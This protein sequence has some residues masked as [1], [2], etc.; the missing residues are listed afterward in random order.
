MAENQGSQQSLDFSDGVI[1]NN[2][3]SR[4]IFIFQTLYV[5]S[6]LLKL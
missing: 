5:S 3:K 4:E 6:D 2:Y 1:Y